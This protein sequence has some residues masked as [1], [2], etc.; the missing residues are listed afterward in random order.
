MLT[1]SK[2]TG[3]PWNWLLTK[4]F[5]FCLS[6]SKMTVKYQSF[7]M[8][9]FR[10]LNNISKMILV[11]SLK[12]IQQT[13]QI[14]NRWNHLFFQIKLMNCLM[15]LYRLFMQIL[16]NIICNINH[17]PSKLW[18]LGRNIAVFIIWCEFEWIKS[19]IKQL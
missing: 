1:V 12:A 18:L 4:K 6:F 3:T 7:Y 2:R 19:P 9:L 16:C 14:A 8:V 15:L 10:V 13:M 5:G 11:E 17:Y